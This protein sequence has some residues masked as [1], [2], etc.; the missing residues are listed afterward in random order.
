MEQRDQHFA[1]KVKIFRPPLPHAFF[2]TIDHH[3]ISETN[4]RTERGDRG[5]EKMS[6]LVHLPTPVA[7]P[8]LSVPFAVAAC[9]LATISYVG[10]LYLHPAGRLTNA[11][12][13][14]GNT[15]DRDHPVVIKARIK[16]ATLA[17]AVIS[18]ATGMTLWI[19]GAVPSAGWLLD[20]LNLS[21]LLGMPLPV[22]T[23]LS[24]ALLPFNPPLGSYF[25]TLATHAGSA[26]LLTGM[27]FLGPLYV[28]YLDQ[29]LPFQRFFSLKQDVVE[30]L[31]TLPGIRNYLVGPVTEELVFRSTILT[32]LHS[33]ALSRTSLIFLSPAFFGIAHAHHAYNVYL[34]HG[35]TAA[36]LKRG[37]LIAALQTVYTGVFG[38]YAN[39][40]FLRSGTVWGPVAAHVWCNVMGLPNPQEAAERHP[41]R[42]LGKYPPHRH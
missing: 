13:E 41:K 3:P 7:P 11:K 32:L 12:D 36:A 30:K 42:S 23:V 16:T 38:W 25:G 10:S 14:E 20:T 34:T 15:L 21:R 35:R 19:K 39:F 28:A 5:K 40:L 31:T 22:P 33:A 4:T 2:L 18:V 24:S 29:S 6:L 9:T 37:I 27:L 17:T 26:L 1:H 8:I